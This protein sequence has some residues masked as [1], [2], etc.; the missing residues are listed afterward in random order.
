MRGGTRRLLSRHRHRRLPFA[1]SFGP[2]E[3]KRPA[4]PPPRRPTSRFRVR[5]S[6]RPSAVGRS[7]STMSAQPLILLSADSLKD[8]IEHR[9]QVGCRLRLSIENAR[10]NAQEGW[11]GDLAVTGPRGRTPATDQGKELIQD[12]RATGIRAHFSAMTSTPDEWLT[13]ASRGS[14]DADGTGRARAG[15]VLTGGPRRCSHFNDAG[16]EVEH[17]LSKRCAS[18]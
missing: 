18:T 13:N 10:Q 14:Q 15:V 2:A 1:P 3:L 17:R 8:C 5:P 16:P 4:A 6:L 12:G 11:A 7:L 9:T